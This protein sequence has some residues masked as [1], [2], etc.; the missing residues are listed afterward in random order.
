[1]SK[2]KTLLQ[3]GTTVTLAI[4]KG[5]VLVSSAVSKIVAHSATLLDKFDIRVMPN[6]CSYNST[7]DCINPSQQ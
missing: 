3:G 2:T 5:M 6:H 1:M 4:T 7:L